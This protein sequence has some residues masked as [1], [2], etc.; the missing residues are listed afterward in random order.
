MSALDDKARELGFKIKKGPTKFS[1]HILQRLNV[2]KQSTP[3]TNWARKETVDH[4]V[5]DDELRLDEFE[6]QVDEYPL[7]SDFKWS[8]AEIEDYLES[9]A[10]DI[11]AGRVKPTD[12]DDAEPEVETS[13]KLAKVKPPSRQERAD[14]LRGHDAAAEIR[15]MARSAKVADQSGKTWHDLIIEQRAVEARRH[16]AIEQAWRTNLDSRYDPM[17]EDDRYFIA[18]M[19]IDPEKVHQQ[20]LERIRREDGAFIPPEPDGYATPKPATGF[21]VERKGRRKPV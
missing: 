6:S 7:G 14:A 15:A 19:F 13:A 8:L 1:G 4:L 9:V 11:A 17:G 10:A 2:A 16:Y 3:E 5:D 21:Q 12:E 18:D 20:E